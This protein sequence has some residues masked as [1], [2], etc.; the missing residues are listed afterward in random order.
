M[1]SGFWA[2]VEK[3]FSDAGI[4]INGNNSWD[5]KIHND[6]V[7]RRF[8]AGGSLAL[9][10][11]Y[12]DGWWDVDKL[13]DFFYRIFQTDLADKVKN[14]W[15]AISH[16]MLAKIF[17]FQNRA[18]AFEIGERHYDVDESVYRA[19]LGESMTYTCGYFSAGAG[20]LDQAQLAKLDLVCRK[21]G[22][23]KGDRVLDIG[24]GWGSFAKLAAEKYGAEV[25]GVT[26][27]RNQVEYAKEKYNGLPIDIRFQDYRDL[28]G[29]FDHIVSL[30]MF[31][32][33]G[34]KNYRIYMEVVKKCL[35]KDGLFLLHT[36]GGNH[37][38][39]SVDP[40]VN[41]YIFPNGMLPSIKQIGRSIENLFV[42]EDWHNF[43]ADYDKTLMAWHS[44]FTANWVKTGENRDQRFIRMWNYYLLSSAA[45]FRARR[46]QLWQVVL[47]PEGVLGGYKSV[48]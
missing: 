10:E 48:R 20:D 31:E 6:K 30:G 18:R 46:N 22:L 42:M 4:A 43:S 16:V 40:W 21:I 8:L 37:S 26:V 38:V 36:I 3:L 27:S 5:I 29:K 28:N 14:N 41:K 44:N 2:V 23:K 13:D 34:V 33:V 35:K 47:S 1:S 17:N 25:V 45:S 39:N 15:S 19:M 11:S 7:Y 32:H 9:G 24:C 12:V